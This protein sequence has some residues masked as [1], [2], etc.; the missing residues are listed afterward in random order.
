MK[1][2]ANR[3]QTGRILSVVILLIITVSTYISQEHLKEAM[4]RIVTSN[5][6]PVV[7]SELLGQLNQLAVKGR[8][9]KTEYSRSQFG[10]GWSQIDGCDTRN[11]ILKRDLQNVTIDPTCRILN[12]TLQDPYTGKVIQFVRGNQTSQLVQID[13]IV[14]LSN[15][16]QTGAQQL[17]RIQREAFAN[18][19]L[20][21]L[22]VDGKT[23][24]NKSDG[25]AATWL[26]PNKQF[27]CTYISRQITIKKQYVLWVTEAEKTAMVQVIE[28]CAQ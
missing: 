27:R 24:Q 21:L 19:P 5:T 20:N 28:K 15:A 8:A 12:G 7:S 23:N 4:P 1:L 3:N 2:M 6:I 10:D 26:P 25:D 22:A 14:S 17:T 16:W 9:P 13:H 11:M 18:D